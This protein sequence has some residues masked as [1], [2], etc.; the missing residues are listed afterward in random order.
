MEGLFAACLSEH[1]QQVQ[2]LVTDTDTAH[3]H[4][5]TAL[6][7]HHTG[8]LSQ[9]TDLSAQR[10][11]MVQQHHSWYT[12]NTATN[13]DNLTTMATGVTG[14][15]TQARNVLRP[16]LD[17]LQAHLANNTGAR[18]GELEKHIATTTAEV[19][20]VVRQEAA[21]CATVQTQLATLHTGMDSFATGMS[22]RYG[23]D[24]T[25]YQQLTGTLVT[26]HTDLFTGTEQDLQAE[27]SQGVA[28]EAHTQDLQ[29][30]YAAQAPDVTQIPSQSKQRHDPFP[31]TRE[32]A[33]IRTEVG[34]KY[35]HTTGNTNGNGNG[36][37]TGNTVPVSPVAVPYW[38]EAL[39]K[40]LHEHVN[41]LQ[42]LQ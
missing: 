16:A 28:H 10:T 8:I 35:G 34:R 12:G 1:Q 21:H 22:S 9:Y 15:D 41:E 14:M 13:T 20:Q 32:H 33:H 3:Q 30:Q 11:G 5:T 27:K 36:K 24:T 29:A 37:L 23:T 38:Q 2:T 42:E 39:Q 6:Q 40:F 17:T 7:D 19:Q 4:F 25:T 31:A 18:T 26:A